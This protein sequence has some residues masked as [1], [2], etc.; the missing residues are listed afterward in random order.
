MLWGRK[1]GKYS[2]PILPNF[3]II[4]QIIRLFGPHNSR[5]IE[6]V[7]ISLEPGFLF[8]LLQENIFFV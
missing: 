6:K 4:C 7:Y 1:L 8:F 5:A 3:L 2:H